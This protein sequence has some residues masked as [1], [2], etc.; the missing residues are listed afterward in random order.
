M[1]SLFVFFAQQNATVTVMIYDSR[2]GI[3]QDTIDV[4]TV[5]LNDHTLPTS[6]LKY[7]GEYGIASMTLGFCISN[8]SD[9]FVRTSIH[10]SKCTVHRDLPVFMNEK[11][12]AKRYTKMILESCLPFVCI[13]FSS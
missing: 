13:I 8:T 3:P 10:R 6:P 12:I 5:N 11:D 7:M 2:D 4:V 1:C 9:P